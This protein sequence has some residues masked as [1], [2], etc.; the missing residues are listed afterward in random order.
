MKIKF[1]APD[2]CVASIDCMRRKN[3]TYTFLTDLQLI[4]HLLFTFIIQE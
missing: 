3:I 2:P 4:S 1:T